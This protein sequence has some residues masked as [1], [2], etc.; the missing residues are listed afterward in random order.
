MKHFIRTITFIAV[1][2]INSLIKKLKQPTNF[3]GKLD[4]HITS[5]WGRSCVSK[6]T[7][8]H[9]CCPL[10]LFPLRPIFRPLKSVSKISHKPTLTP[11]SH[12]FRIRHV[13]HKKIFSNLVFMFK[14]SMWRLKMMEE[15]KIETCNGNPT[16]SRKLS[17]TTFLWGGGSLF[18]S[19][20]VYCWVALAF[21]AGACFS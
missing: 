16:Q 4:K 2:F 14:L 20:K 18:I 5:L 21:F 6:T 1:P 8:L 17:L 7:R 15:K 12:R 9:K 3:A 10:M 13:L 11:H 19:L